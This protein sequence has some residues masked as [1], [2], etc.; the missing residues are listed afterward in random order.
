MRFEFGNSNWVTVTG[1][2][3]SIVCALAFSYL[4]KSAF[5]QFYLMRVHEL[6]TDAL[7]AAVLSPGIKESEASA[8]SISSDSSL[9]RTP[10]HG[11]SSSESEH[12]P[13][14]EHKHPSYTS[15]LKKIWKTAL[16]VFLVFFVTLLIYPGLLVGIHSQFD[17]VQTEE[18]LPVILTVRWHWLDW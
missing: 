13:S 3:F 16:A 6:E 7:I 4:I 12:D 5:T 2:A 18:W 11:S 9:G 14:A 10:S 15:V 17:S 8:V 1:S